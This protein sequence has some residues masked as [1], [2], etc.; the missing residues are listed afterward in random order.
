LYN[1]ADSSGNCIST[2]ATPISVIF[3]QNVVYSCASSN[4]CASSL[5]I[6]SITKT[7]S[8]EIQKWAKNSNTTIVFSGT[9]SSVNTCSS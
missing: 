9:G 5:Y 4:P 3:D 8:L 6:D 7:S 2:G 1:I